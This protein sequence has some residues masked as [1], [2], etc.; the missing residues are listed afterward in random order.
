[1]PA[2]DGNDAALH[3]SRQASATHDIMEVRIEGSPEVRLR[4]EAGAGESAP[5]GA[6]L[7]RHP[8]QKPPSWTNG[9]QR[10]GPAGRR[11]TTNQRRH[12][13]RGDT[14][15]MIRDPDRLPLSGRQPGGDAVQAARPPCWMAAAVDQP[16]LLAASATAGAK[17]CRTRPLSPA[18]KRHLRQPHQTSTSSSAAGRRAR[19][20]LPV[21]RADPREAEHRRFL[22]SGAEEVRAIARTRLRT[23]DTGTQC[24]DGDPPRHCRPARRGDQRATPQFRRQRPGR[25]DVLR[26]ADDAAVIIGK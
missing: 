24:L 19:T 23:N 6:V 5:P 4:G 9:D 17:K 7:Q 11:A 1:M 16:G 12:A 10:P 22:P 14:W 3:E 15:K 26:S 25:G 18:L 21:R 8:P 13:E 20:S 2:D